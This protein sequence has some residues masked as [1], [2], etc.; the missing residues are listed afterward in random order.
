ME[1]MNYY[2]KLSGKFV[3]TKKCREYREKIRITSETS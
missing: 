3:A 1:I 2:S